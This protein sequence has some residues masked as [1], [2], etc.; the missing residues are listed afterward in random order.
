MTKWLAKY[1]IMEF[2][3]ENFSGKYD[4]E[5]DL[6]MHRDNLAG[7]RGGLPVAY[8]MTLDQIGKELGITRERVRMIQNNA[9]GKLRHPKNSRLLRGFLDG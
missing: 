6:G 3:G 1:L 8:H 7:G 9:L 2:E 5:L 4:G